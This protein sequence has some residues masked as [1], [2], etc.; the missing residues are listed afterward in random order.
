MLRNPR[1]LVV[2][3][4]GVSGAGKTTVGRLLAKDV[5]WSFYDGDDFISERGWDNGLP[6]GCPAPL[7]DEIVEPHFGTLRYLRRRRSSDTA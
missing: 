1:C 2:I 6:F 5:G 4:I 3:L 7:R